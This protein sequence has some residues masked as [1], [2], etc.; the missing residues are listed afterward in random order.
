MGISLKGIREEREF[1]EKFLT[2]REPG[3]ISIIPNIDSLNWE[4]S[5][6]AAN[7]YEVILKIKTSSSEYLETKSTGIN[8]YSCVRTVADHMEKKA[9]KT[10]DKD[11][12]E[13][14]SNK[15]YSNHKN[16]VA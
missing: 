11:D 1:L 7:C 15:V 10:F 8:I 4:C 13:N 9:R 14:W 12:I 2:K 5:K 16:K 6:K 3:I